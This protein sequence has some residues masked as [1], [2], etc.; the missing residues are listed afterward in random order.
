MVQVR[1][2]SHLR[3]C[4]ISTA[5]LFCAIAVW[6]A[7]EPATDA[8][9][10]G[11][12]TDPKARKTFAEAVEWQRKN[13]SIAAIDQYRKAYKQDGGHC[14]ECLKRAYS[15]ALNDGLYDQ[16][17]D[18]ARDWLAASTTDSE[19]AFNH[20]RLAVALQRKGIADKKRN[21]STI[22]ATSSSPLRI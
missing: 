16:A 20:Y 7:G 17:A 5:F 3:L 13:D 21:A 22:V 15:L 8:P 6:A 14:V 10:P 9:K 1:S 12:P 2:F 18:V 11:E 4:A 19:K